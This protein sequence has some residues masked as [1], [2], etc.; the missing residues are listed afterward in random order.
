MKVRIRKSSLK[1]RRQHGF[2][3][4]PGSYMKKKTKT[5][6]LRLVLLGRRKRKKSK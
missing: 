3:S 1:A 2:R 4:K 5:K 6:N